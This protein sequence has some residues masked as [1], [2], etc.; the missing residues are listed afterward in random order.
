MPKIINDGSIKNLKTNKRKKIKN[1]LLLS[2]G[3]T[4]QSFFTCGA[5][6][7]I[8]DNDLFDFDVITAVSGGTLMLSAL[9]WCTNPALNYYKEPDWY[10]RYIR[11][12]MY[13]GIDG[14]LLP[15]AIK[16]TMSF[17]QLAEYFAGFV[18]GFKKTVDVENTNVVCEYYYIDANSAVLTCD[19][20]DIIDIPN[21]VQKPSW[22]LIR[23]LRCSMPILNLENKPTYD[24]GLVSNVPT[25]VFFS[26]YDAQN[27]FIVQACPAFTYDTYAPSFEFVTDFG[28]KCMRATSNVFQ[29]TIAIESQTCSKVIQCS[30]SNGLNPSEDSI[31]KGLF[32]DWGAECPL[33][34]WMFNGVLV[35]YKPLVQIIENEGYIQM[36]YKLKKAYPTKKMVFKIP[37]PE[38]Y[39]TDVKELK[40]EILSRNIGY[41]FV[42]TVI[43]APVIRKSSK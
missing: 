16:N 15:A 4:N 21:H 35:N 23:P 37:N 8:V 22:W 30:M 24:A 17:S 39:N 10:N 3:G 33:S 28:F 6:K 14:V 43:N 27:V 40:R 42:K 7:C 13:A 36:Y 20:T 2:G 26:R 32:Y 19:H 12:S 41:E 1:A 18:P 11:K 9:D 38:V 34:V 29:D 31:H 5:L 25:S